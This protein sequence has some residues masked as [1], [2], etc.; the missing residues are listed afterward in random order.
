MAPDAIPN[1]NETTENEANNKHDL[2]VEDETYTQLRNALDDI[3][4]TPARIKPKPWSEECR[5]VTY[6][7]GD[8]I[9]SHNEVV[10]PEFEG[11]GFVLEADVEECNHLNQHNANFS[12]GIRKARRNDRYGVYCDGVA[13]SAVGYRLQSP[14]GNVDYLERKKESIPTWFAEPKK[15]T[16]VFHERTLSVF[17]DGRLAVYAT[18]LPKGDYHPRISAF[19]TTATFSNIR[20]AQL[21]SQTRLPKITIDERDQRAADRFRKRNITTAS[22]VGSRSDDPSLCRVRLCYVHGGNTHF[23]DDDLA[24][25]NDSNALAQLCAGDASGVSDKGVESLAGK[26][27]LVEL[28][29]IDSLIQGTTLSALHDS[30]GFRKLRLTNAK[31][32]TD[33]AIKPITKLDNLRW[34]DLNGANISGKNFS[35][36]KNA[37]PKMW[38]FAIPNFPTDDLSLNFIGQWKNLE[39]LYPPADA[40]GK[41]LESLPDNHGLTHLLAGNTKLSDENLPHLARLPKLKMLLASNTKVTDLG[42]VHIGKVISLI[43]LNLEQTEVS[44]KGLPNLYSMTNLR[45]LS[46]VGTNVTKEGVR[47]LE[48]ALPDCQIKSQHSASQ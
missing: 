37:N 43:E 42:L 20:I 19:N 30:G 22:I 35:L 9:V 46:L 16:L 48:Q 38:V 27:D 23:T 11:T 14:N 47:K 5:E 2:N 17:A 15:L 13:G 44:D 39:W 36:F 34:L 40:S 26:P 1:S 41:Y 33:V 18:G 45:G 7:A 8:L 6:D 28:T 12:F 4:Q 25:L 29:L 24:T 10:F 3:W 32:L 21:S 31:K